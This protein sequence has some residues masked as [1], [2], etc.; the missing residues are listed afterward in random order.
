MLSY[1][2]VVITF[3]IVKQALIKF[4]DC[5]DFINISH[6]AFYYKIRL[7][8]TYEILADPDTKYIISALVNSL[9]QDLL[10]H[11]SGN[12]IKKLF[13]LPTL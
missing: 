6:I 10:D 13:R 3:L 12:N 11:I 9:C 5:F 7:V 4:T 8:L 2:F 1:L